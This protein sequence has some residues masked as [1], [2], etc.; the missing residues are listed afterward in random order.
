[1]IEKGNLKLSGTPQ[2]VVPEFM[3]I[4]VENSKS[5]GSKSK[6]QEVDNELPLGLSSAVSTEES[7]LTIGKVWLEDE[8]SKPIDMLKDNIPEYFV[9]FMIEAKSDVEGITPGVIVT[10]DLGEFVVATNSKWAGYDS[11]NI[12]NKK[13]YH[14]RFKMLNIYEQGDYKISVN[15][16]SKDLETFYAW[17]NEAASVYVDKP[18]LTGA[19]AN[20]KS[21]VEI[22]E[23]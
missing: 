11:K 9:N 18:Y 17:K 2:V 12:V 15:V 14:V 19:K 21:K 16:V 22:T 3:S 5:E 10:N 23:V 1:L 8:D 6:A 7:A 20:P 13:K 4:F